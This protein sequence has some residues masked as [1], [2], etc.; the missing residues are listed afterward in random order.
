GGAGARGLDVAVDGVLAGPSALA[1]GA[2]LADDEERGEQ[3]EE[4]DEDGPRGRHF[5]TDSFDSGNFASAA[6]TVT[7]S[8]FFTSSSLPFFRSVRSK[9]PTF[10]SALLN[11]TVSDWNCRSSGRARRGRGRRSSRRTRRRG[12]A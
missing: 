8:V 12:R 3:G 6:P 11:F 4:G 1:G 5:S 10:F 9:L 7:S 2:D